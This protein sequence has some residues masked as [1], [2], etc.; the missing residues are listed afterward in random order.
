MTQPSPTPDDVRAPFVREQRYIVIKLKLL[1]ERASEP[2][3]RYLK[4][5]N[6]KPVECVVV[7]ADWPEYE[8]VW[9]MIEARVTGAPV[10]PDDVRRLFDEATPGGWIA[11]AKPSMHGWPIVSGEGRMIA[12]MNY[13]HHSA[14]DPKVPGDVAF[15]RE[16]KANAAFIAA[17]RSGWP[18][19]RERAD[20]AEAALAFY[21][22]PDGD[23][24]D[25]I[26]TDYGLST[27]N[28]DIIKDR[29]AIA[30]TALENR[31]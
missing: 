16:S 1:Q 7:E 14:I 31:P 9:Q 23:G 19:D 30:R 27:D 22:D 15:N 20:R 11:A 18:A 2:L 5:L 21:A 4:H 25:V 8:T 24:Y 29:G 28:G 10:T 3:R 12:S 17:A 13:V 6:V 26:V